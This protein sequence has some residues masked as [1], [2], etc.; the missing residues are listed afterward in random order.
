MNFKTY[1]MVLVGAAIAT[2]FSPTEAASYC[3]ST[4]GCAINTYSDSN[5]RISECCEKIGG[6]FAACCEGS[7]N[8]GS[9]CN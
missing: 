2:S 5:V 3:P 4:L 8:F 7:C 6:D 9:P 1:V